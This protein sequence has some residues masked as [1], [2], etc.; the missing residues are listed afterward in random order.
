MFFCSDEAVKL[1]HDVAP[2]IVA[3]LILDAE[4]DFTVDIHDESA[5]NQ[6]L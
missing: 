5:L 1:V 6:L 3:C 4:S 2:L